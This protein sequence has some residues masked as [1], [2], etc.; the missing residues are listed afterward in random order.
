MLFVSHVSGFNVVSV[1]YMQSP[2]YQISNYHVKIMHL[3]FLIFLLLLMTLLHYSHYILLTY[4]LIT[5]IHI[6]V[7]THFSYFVIYI[8]TDFRYKTT[9][10]QIDCTCEIKTLKLGDKIS[11]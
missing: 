11:H 9:R 2:V 3:V 8:S 6:C 5:N 7:L 10:N 4:T 1:V